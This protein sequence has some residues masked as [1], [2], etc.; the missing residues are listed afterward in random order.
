MRRYFNFAAY[1]GGTHIPL[2]AQP[3][4]FSSDPLY[5]Y[6]K[7]ADGL[8]PVSGS[9]QYSMLDLKQAVSDDRFGGA[10]YVELIF[11]GFF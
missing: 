10:A 11:T 8:V 6:C 9:Q 1:G 3:T 7:V 2:N 4:E 5:C